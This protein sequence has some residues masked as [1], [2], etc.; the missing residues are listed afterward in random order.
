MRLVLSLAALLSIVGQVGAEPNHR[1]RLADSADAACF[2]N[3]ASQS[4]S[5][6]RVCPSTFSAP[7]LAACD[8]QYQSCTQSCQKK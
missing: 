4:A 2:A 6:K 3:C 7:C 8:S 1:L 5:C